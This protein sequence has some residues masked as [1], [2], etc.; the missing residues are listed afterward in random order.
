MKDQKDF[1][2]V[3]KE[4]REKEL[5]NKYGVELESK[6]KVNTKNRE[7]FLVRIKKDDRQKKLLKYIIQN[8]GK[9]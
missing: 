6:N 9:G 2:K 8:V 4:V 1:K 5:S 7:K 3:A